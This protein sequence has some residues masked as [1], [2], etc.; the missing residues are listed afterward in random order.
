MQRDKRNKKTFSL[1]WQFYADAF[2]WMSWPPVRDFLSPRT[3]DHQ[4]M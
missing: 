3:Y 2:S 1:L 4:V